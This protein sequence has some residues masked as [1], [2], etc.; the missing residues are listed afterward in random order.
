MEMDIFCRIHVQTTRYYNYKLF[1]IYNRCVN[2][3]DQALNADQV[4]KESLL[5]FTIFLF[6]YIII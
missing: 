3:I 1:S 5:F 6:K 2:L 4:R